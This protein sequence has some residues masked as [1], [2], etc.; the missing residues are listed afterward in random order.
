M[1]YLS[2]ERFAKLFNA[3]EKGAEII[4]SNNDEFQRGFLLVK[5][6]FVNFLKFVTVV[7][8]ARLSLEQ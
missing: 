3:K 6:K 7:H 5:N 2:C 1:Q 4:S 8:D